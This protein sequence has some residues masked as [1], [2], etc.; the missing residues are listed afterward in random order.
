MSR[1]LLL[2]SDKPLP[3]CDRQ[4]ERTKTS[5]I[6][7]ETFSVTALFGFRVFEHAY[8]RGA[9][10]ELNLEM[11]PH[12]YELELEADEDDLA[13]FKAYLEENFSPGETFELWN[14]W[15]GTDDLGHPTRYHGALAD[16]DMETLRQFLLPTHPD[17]G[18]GQCRM[19]VTV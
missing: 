8:Y 6:A 1:V 4:C 19:T 14:V 3:F 15:V 10:E 11:K 17:G 16:F 5:V 12:R 7:G 9:V 18:P 2:A 13:H